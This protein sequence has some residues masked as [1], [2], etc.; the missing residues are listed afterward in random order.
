MGMRPFVIAVEGDFVDDGKVETVFC[1][2][3]VEVAESQLDAQVQA[4]R[5]WP[6]Y[7][8]FTAAWEVVPPK[9]RLAALEAD[10]QIF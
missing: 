5:R 1:P 2:L 4:S 3:G 9:A 8:V 6:F 7:N 10:R